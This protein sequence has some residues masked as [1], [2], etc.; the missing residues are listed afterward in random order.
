M[1][2]GHGELVQEIK[3]GGDEVSWPCV[4]G[5]ERDLE[6]HKQGEEEERGIGEI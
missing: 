4:P 3:D 6:R 1:L 5:P 2:H